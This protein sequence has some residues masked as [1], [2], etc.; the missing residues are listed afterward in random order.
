[1]R[2]SRPPARVPPVR[3]P[4]GG[5]PWNSAR[6]KLKRASRPA[7]APAGGRR[8]SPPDRFELCLVKVEPALP[9]GRSVRLPAPCAR[10]AG[11]PASRPGRARLPAPARVPP[12]RPPPGGVPWNCARSKLKRPSRPASAPADGRRTSP[13][14]RFELCLVKVEPA[15]PPGRSVRL[16][17]PGARPAG[18]PASRQGAEGLCLV[19][20]EPARLPAACAPPRR[21]ASSSAWSKLNQPAASTWL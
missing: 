5:M 2:A 20:V 6:S 19:K 7:S 11:A 15:L 13:P 21:V 3:P 8:T 9:P 4:P 18:A 16:P 17:A 1:M 14:D 12:V 10:P